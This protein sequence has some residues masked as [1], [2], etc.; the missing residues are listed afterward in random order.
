VALADLAEVVLVVAELEEVIKLN[1]YY[2]KIHKKGLS[3]FS[4]QAFLYLGSELLKLVTFWLSIVLRCPNII[5]PI[6]IW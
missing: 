3:R 4:A 2:S 1:R 5:F 6:H